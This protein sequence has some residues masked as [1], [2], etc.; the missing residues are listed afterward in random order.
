MT[1]MSPGTPYLFNIFHLSLPVFK[2]GFFYSP[3]EKQKPSPLMDRVFAKEVYGT[4]GAT[5]NITYAARLIW[6][7]NH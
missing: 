6:V 3:T 1:L 4:K 5:V 7:H 2:A